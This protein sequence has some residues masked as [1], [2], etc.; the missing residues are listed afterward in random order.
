MEVLSNDEIINFLDNIENRLSL[1]FNGSYIIIRRISDNK[2][3]K[4]SKKDLY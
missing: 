2:I 4:R 1:H 3:I